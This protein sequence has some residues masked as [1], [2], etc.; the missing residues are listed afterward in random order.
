[1]THSHPQSWI[2]LGLISP[3]QN[4]AARLL[5]LVN[6]LLVEGLINSNTMGSLKTF[7][8]KFEQRLEFKLY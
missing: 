6:D 7:L 4:V 2:I 1:M 5:K 8:I 3:K